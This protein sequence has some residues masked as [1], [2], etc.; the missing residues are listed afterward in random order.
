MAPSGGF[1]FIRRRRQQRR[2]LLR[3]GLRCTA[4][5]LCGADDTLAPPDRPYFFRPSL[6]VL[7]FSSDPL[8]L[9]FFTL[10]L[11]RLVWR[12]GSGF[13]QHPREEYRRKSS[14]NEKKKKMAPD[15]WRIL[16][17]ACR[18]N[19]RKL[20]SFCVHDR[21]FYFQF[22]DFA[23]PSVMFYDCFPLFL[24]FRASYVFASLCVRLLA[25]PFLL[26]FCSFYD[27]SFICRNFCA[28]ASNC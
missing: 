4:P 3:S 19:N 6:L 16:T 9:S 25:R 2:R 27:C 8:F 10:L 18:P 13:F 26:W 17:A 28:S 23:A 14:G 21:L 7:S 15:T 5:A 20:R 24:F 22:A 11:R 1:P 12:P